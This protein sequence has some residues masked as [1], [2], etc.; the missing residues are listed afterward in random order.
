MPRLDLDS[1]FENKLKKH[2]GGVDLRKA[3]AD[4]FIKFSQP[5]VPRSLNFKPIKGTVNSYSIRVLGKYTGWRILMRKIEDDAGVYY[6]AFDFDDH[7]IRR[8]R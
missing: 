7:D 3:I 2:N 5:N 4:S 8:Q 6:L 1:P